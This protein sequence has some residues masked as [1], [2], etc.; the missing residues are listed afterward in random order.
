MVKIIK[1]QAETLDQ[2]KAKFAD[3]LMTG[4]IIL[5]KKEINAYDCRNTPARYITASRYLASADDVINE[6]RK[7]LPD[8]GQIREI[9]GIDVK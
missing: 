3:E 1:V 7:H 5:E 2:A 9:A 6:A 4:F 8:S